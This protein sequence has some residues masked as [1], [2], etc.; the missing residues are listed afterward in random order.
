METIYQ[1]CRGV[2]LEVCGILKLH[3]GAPW[4][5]YHGNVIKQLDQAIRQAQEADRQARHTGDPQRM[6]QCRRQLNTAR[7]VKL[8]QIRTWETEWLSQ[9][10]EEA[11]RTLDTPAA[12]NIFQLVKELISAVGKGSRDG[13]QAHAG[14]PAEVEAW[15]DHF[16]ATQQGIGEVD[17]SIWPDI[18]QR[19]IDTSLDDPPSWEEFLRAIKE[20]R[21]G[22]AGGEDT[23]LAE[24]IKFGGP[25][26]RRRCTVLYRN[27]GSRLPPH[28][29]GRKQKVGLL[30]GRSALLCPFGNANNQGL[31]NTIGVVS[32]CCR[33]VASW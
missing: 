11:N 26:L 17:D 24:Y 27:V 33:L 15:K 9:K 18:S 20:M 8:Q 25:Q 14:S 22:K 2:A 6:Q 4:L 29:L 30:N 10:A 28:H 19:P 13:G 32:P 31:I 7:R 16:Q 12:T 3:K 1:I 23:M 21:L 5:R